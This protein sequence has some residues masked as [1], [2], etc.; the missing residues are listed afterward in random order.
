MRGEHPRDL[1]A[2][3][4]ARGIIPA[5]AGSTPYLHVDGPCRTGSSPH[6]RGALGLAIAGVSAAMDHPRMRGE[7]DVLQPGRSRPLGI[8]PACAGSTALEIVAEIRD[9]GS[10]PHARGAPRPRTS[11]ATSPRDHPRMRGEHPEVPRHPAGAGGGIIPA[12][13]GSTCSVVTVCFITEGSSPH[14]RGAQASERQHTEDARDHPRMR[15]EHRPVIQAVLPAVG[16]IPACAGSTV[17]TS[18]SALE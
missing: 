10:S 13:A 5:C 18:S 2:E 6:A 3:G 12:C 11:R 4:D 8:I 7:H 1:H 14:A 17:N 15:G 16:I 9:Y